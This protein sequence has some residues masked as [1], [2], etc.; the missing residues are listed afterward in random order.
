MTAAGRFRPT[1]LRWRGWSWPGDQNDRPPA[2]LFVHLVGADGRQVAGSDRP[3]ASGSSEAVEWLRLDVPPSKPASWAL[4]SASVRPVRRARS[5][6]GVDPYVFGKTLGATA[7]WGPLWW[8]L[9]LASEPGLYAGKVRIGD[10]I[11]LNGHPAS[12]RRR[13]C[14]GRRSARPAADYTASSMRWTTRK[15]VAQA[16]GLGLAISEWDAGRPGETIVDRH[17]PSLRGVGPDAAS[18]ASTSWRRS[19]ACRGAAGKSSWTVCKGLGATLRRPSRAR[20]GHL[21]GVFEV[22]A[23]RQAPARRVTRTSRPR[24]GR[25]EHRRG[26]CPCWDWWPG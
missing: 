2:T 26:I 23:D 22:A 8:L 21:V 4:Q 17:R 24:A 16:D 20:Q 6:L 12:S 25:D 9:L 11:E 7:L 19:N 1:A 18:W 13:G 5:A 10:Q 3:S 15:V 14:N